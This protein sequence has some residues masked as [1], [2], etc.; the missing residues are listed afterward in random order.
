MIRQL[1]YD[2]LDVGDWVAEV[3]YFTISAQVVDKLR[4]QINIP[5]L[6]WLL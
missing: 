6:A 5:Y 2:G 3:A 4:I 1:S